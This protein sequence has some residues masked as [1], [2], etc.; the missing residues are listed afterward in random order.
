MLLKQER[1]RSAEIPTSSLADISFLLLCFFLV[2]TTFDV[3]KG[4]GLTLPPIGQ[5]IK[6]REKNITN[7]LINE[8]GQ[9]LIDNQSVQI[10]AIK[11]IIRQKLLQN[12]KLIV[13]I[14]TQRKTKYNVYIKVLDKIKE[15]GETRISIAEPEK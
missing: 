14:K 5:E 3:D 11:D 7:V 9:V 2:T 8:Q 13:S 4:I 15:S 12:P 6:V 1:E 10:P